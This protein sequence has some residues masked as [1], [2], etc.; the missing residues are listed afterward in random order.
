[1]FAAIGDG[2][3][4]LALQRFI[5]WQIGLVTTKRGRAFVV[6]KRATLNERIT[7]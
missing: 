3:L 2:P 5:D 4:R 7:F 1:M 6:M